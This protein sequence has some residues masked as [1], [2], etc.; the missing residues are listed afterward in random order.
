[1]TPDSRSDYVLPD[2]PDPAHYVPLAEHERALAALRDALAC[3]MTRIALLGP[4]GFGKSLLLRR[5][6]SDAP[7]LSRVFYVPFATLGSE[8][9]G[10]WL[11]SWMGGRSAQ[12][13]DDDLITWVRVEHRLG[14][15]CVILLD[16]A[17]SLPLHTAK[18]L[19]EWVSRAQGALQLVLSGIEGE[20][21]REV[22]EAFGPS[23]HRV[24]LR[25][26]LRGEALRVFAGALVERSVG[27]RGDA[28][29]WIWEEQELF[30]ATGG[31]PRLVKAE[32]RGRLE[33]IARAPRPETDAAEIAAAQRVA[34]PAL[35]DSGDATARAERSSPARA[36]T[37]RNVRPPAPRAR[38]RR[39]VVPAAALLV[40]LA[41]LLTPSLHRPP[42][43]A[44]AEPP[45]S[46]AAT[47]AA[48]AVAVPVHINAFPWARVHLDGRYVGVTPL[49]NLAVAPGEHE[50]IATFPDGREMIKRI[51]AQ[52]PGASV[53]FP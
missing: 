31:V 2:A 28:P 3:G 30:E 33:K 9:L 44:I 7:P 40:L 15:R 1:M 53:S 38:G 13:S 35:P 19:E 22:L 46:P 14:R 47:P 25:K 26:P 6:A 8:E 27:A 16:E 23:L 36:A 4:P 50:L 34:L 42:V 17:Q 51:D 48:P 5:L 10:P 45:P 39:R 32:L 24:G 11:L 43:S 49:A 37:V 52:A 20:P 12:V 41:L 29:A 21:L 18:R